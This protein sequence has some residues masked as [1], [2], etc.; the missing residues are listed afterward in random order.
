MRDGDVVERELFALEADGLAGQQPLDRGHALPQRRH[1]LLGHPPH[2]PS[3]C[4]NPSP[5]PGRKRPGNVRLMPA[6]SIASTAGWRT[7]PE[8]ML[9]PTGTDSVADSASTDAT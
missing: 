7:N 6:I 8:T 3:H 5:M 9:V 1:R 2:L 4:G